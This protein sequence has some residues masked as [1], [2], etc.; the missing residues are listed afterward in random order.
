[1]S[2]SSRRHTRIRD[3]ARFA[4]VHST[5]GSNLQP[6]KCRLTYVS[7]RTQRKTVPYVQAHSFFHHTCW[8][9]TNT[10]HASI[11]CSFVHACTHTIVTVRRGTEA[12]RPSS[13]RI[14]GGPPHSA[15]ETRLQ[16]DRKHSG[17][18]A[19]VRAVPS[20]PRGPG[21]AERL[22][23]PHLPFL[24]EPIALLLHVRPF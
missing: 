15:S 1:M 19:A 21:E 22:P 17:R 24:R 7:A 3:Y 13:T 9:R 8:R 20:E 23:A 12:P 14:P 6:K 2:T 16:I 4:R 5:Y 11:A 18:A 10:K